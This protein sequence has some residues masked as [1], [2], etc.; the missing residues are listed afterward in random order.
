VYVDDLIITG[1]H[2][3][4][5]FKAE[6]KKMF[7]MSDLG[8]L[9]YYL[10]IEVKQTEE[11]ITVGQSAYATMLVDKSGTRDCNPCASPLETRLKL[12]KKSDSPL[13]NTTEYRSMVESL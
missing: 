5:K 4:N 11:G 13:V 1:H 12:S 10:G 2:G 3:I 9:S 6:M 7:K 8:L